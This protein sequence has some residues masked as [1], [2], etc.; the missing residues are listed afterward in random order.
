MTNPV[1]TV[2]RGLSRVDRRWRDLPLR[3]R[4]TTTAALA[5]T[6]TIVAVVAVAYIAVRHELRGQIDHQLRRQVHE[7]RTTPGFDP[8]TGNRRFTIDTGAG[9]IGGYAQVLD[10]AGQ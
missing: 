5:A 9:V 10:A 3:N 6:I 1:A 7:L 4:L 2:R 8:L